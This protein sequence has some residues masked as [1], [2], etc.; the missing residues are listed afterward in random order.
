MKI[1]ING[2][3]IEIDNNLS[4]GEVLKKLNLEDRVMAVALNM[5]IVKQDVWFEQRVSEGDKL[6]F[7]DFV[8]GG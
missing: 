6:E 3:E 1:V 8:G 7:L 2:D 4:V 5:N